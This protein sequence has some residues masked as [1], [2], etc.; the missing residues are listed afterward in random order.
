MKELPS[1]L[2]L[3]IL[4]DTIELGSGRISKARKILV[5]DTSRNGIFFFLFFFPWRRKMLLKISQD[6]DI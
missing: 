4:M 5:G 2:F 1:C 6:P 3:F